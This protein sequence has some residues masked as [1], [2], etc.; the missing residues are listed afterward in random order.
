[1]ILSTTTALE[2]QRVLRYLGMVSGE[3][4][5]AGLPSAAGGSARTFEEQLLAAKSRALA[6]MEE[7]GEAAGANAIL[8]V[9]LDFT[10]LADSLVL[11]VA[12]GTAVIC[13]EPVTALT[14]LPRQPM[15]FTT[16]QVT[17]APLA[18]RQI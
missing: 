10:T 11:V 3:A 8:A 12:S 7:R 13:E 2:G 5:A 17:A 14:P 9:D 18:F 16:A 6:L 15:R 4:L 1:M